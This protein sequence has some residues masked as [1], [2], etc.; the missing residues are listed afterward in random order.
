MTAVSF[1]G[2]A[3]WN[4]GNHVQKQQIPSSG[5]PKYLEM[6]HSQK[7]ISLTLSMSKVSFATK[8]PQRTASTARILNVGRAASV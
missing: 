3:G 4:S 7:E 1:H 6:V 5:E 2:T 8:S